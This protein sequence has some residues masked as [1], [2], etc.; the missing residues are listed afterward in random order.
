MQ[1]DGINNIYFQARMKVNKANCKELL[2]DYIPISKGT[3]TVSTASSSYTTSG[4]TIIDQLFVLPISDTRSI[5]EAVL[6]SV[7]LKT[8]QEIKKSIY[9]HQFIGDSSAYN[10]I[11]SES[12]SA[13][14][15]NTKGSDILEE[16]IKKLKNKNIP[17]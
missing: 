13:V 12:I 5:P 2:E 15:L 16:R 6:N 1:I 4:A 3:S 8:S 17:S 14:S 10:T 7:D 11:L 9:D